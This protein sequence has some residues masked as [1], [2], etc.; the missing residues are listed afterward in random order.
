[1]VLACLVIQ[2]VAG[3]ASIYLYSFF[4]GEVETAF[5]SDRATVML[6]ATGH[7]VVAGLLGPKLGD[8]LDRYSLRRIL[9]ASS[10]TM[11]AGFVLISFT[12]GVWGFIA[13]YTLLI[14][15]GSAALVTLFAPLL[16]SRWFV[17]HRGL[18]IGIAALGTQLGGLALPPVVALLTEEFDWRFAM[19]AVGVFVAAAVSM[20]SYWAIV[21][22]PQDRGLAP[23]GDAV[24]VPVAST[25]HGLQ[26]AARASLRAVL[27]DRN[28]W[29]ASF[30]MSAIIAVF[31]VVLSNLVLFATDIGAPRDQ[32]AL[33][34][35]LFA[36]VGLGMSP[37]VGKLCDLLDIRT[38][39]A[40]LLSVSIIALTLFTFAESYRGL[41]TATVIVALAGGGISPFFGALV[42]RLFDLQIFGRAIGCMSLVAVTISAAVPVLSGWLF[43]ATGSYRI[44]FIALIVLMLIPL[45]YMPLIK[46]RPKGV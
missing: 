20:L 35:S 14:P 17:R 22:R 12:P 25:R 37:I 40:G 5:S 46:P 13:G 2:A 43:D 15:F 28:F 44:M 29:L 45:A 33:L 38:V 3:G 6:A 23:D 41:V 16:L 24:A 34:L 11:G 31:S 4:A 9:I 8:L 27:M 36:L 10:L 26:K 18:A 21:D 1:M 42:G 7:A 30:G 39:F 19:R 32:A